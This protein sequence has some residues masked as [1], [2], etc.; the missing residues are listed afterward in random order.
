LRRDILVM[1]AKEFMRWD[2]LLGTDVLSVMIS[3]IAKSVLVVWNTIIVTSSSS[4]YL[5][6]SSH[7]PVPL[8]PPQKNEQIKLP[9]A[10]PA[11]P[12][13]VFQAGDRVR[14]RNVKADM[15][16]AMHKRFGWVSD[17]ARALGEVG[18]VTEVIDDKIRVKVKDS[19]YVWVPAILNHV[20]H[21]SSVAEIGPSKNAEVRFVFI[22]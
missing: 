9:K 22:F 16:K 18:I 4:R 15:A 21:S 10:S 13:P 12:A 2:P 19:T 11:I 8:S 3:T 5:P 20:S 1:N 7:S 14:I 6:P 17:M